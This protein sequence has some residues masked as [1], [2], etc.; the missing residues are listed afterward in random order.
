MPLGALPQ[1]PL[2]GFHVGPVAVRVYGLMFLLALAVGTAILARRW[3]R[4]GGRR[5][6]VYEVVLWSFPAGLIGGRIY[7]LATSW[8][9]VPHGW[10]GPL[11]LWHGGS[12]SWGA[13]AAGVLTAVYVVR[14]HG[15]RWAP[16]LDALA[17]ALLVAQAIG[18]V[19]NWFNQELVG[20][21]SSLPWAVQIDLAHRPA[22]YVEHATFHPAFFYEAAWNLALAAALV[23]LER[24]RRR[25]GRPLRPPGLF[26]LYVAGYALGRVGEELVRV[27][28]A[29]RLLGM[30]VNFW[31]A[32]A[33]FGA[34]L[35]WFAWTQ[36]NGTVR[37]AAARAPAAL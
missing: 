16:F 14:R 17:P 8:D 18:R 12:G 15:A 21:P 11:A 5:E 36:R 2:E 1:P 35:A 13:F 37:A 3:E 34:G 25:A 20:G 4:A 31:V 10:W 9:E 28:P 23:L 7:H 27:D 24:R 22:G 30:R 26:A 33:A 6:L 32:L 19:G 29:H